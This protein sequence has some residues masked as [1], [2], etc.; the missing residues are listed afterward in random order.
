MK[1]NLSKCKKIA[2]LMFDMVP[3]EPGPLG[4][5]QHPWVSSTVCNTMKNGE[6]AFVSIENADFEDCCRENMKIQVEGCKSISNICFYIN[7]PWRLFYIRLL[8]EANII[9]S[10]DLGTALNDIWT[11]VENISGDVNVNYM[12]LV[13]MFQKADENTLMTDEERE[14]L[15]SS[16][17]MLTLYRGVTS[18]N[19]ENKTAM[20]YTDK[21]ETAKWFARRFPSDVRQV[22]KIQIPKSKVIAYYN[23]RDEHEFVI[24]PINVDVIYP[25]EIIRL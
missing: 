19:M 11:T 13:E 25:I 8:F 22:W 1:T 17:D 23:N 9:S 21:E 5:V 10:E 4:I 15:H 24:D 16:K 20:S 7:K 2:K 6:L 18:Y 3:I 14:Y 12:D